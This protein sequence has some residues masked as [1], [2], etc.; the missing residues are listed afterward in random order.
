MDG[1][2]YTSQSAFTKHLGAV[3]QWETGLR[4]SLAQDCLR[5]RQGQSGGLGLSSA[6]S[7]NI[8]KHVNLPD[9]ATRVVEAGQK[10]HGKSEDQ[11]FLLSKLGKDGR[12]GSK[13]N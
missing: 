12:K 1:R 6:S 3:P 10:E 8:W 11:K 7:G 5:Q 4:L 13:Q 2:K 9:T